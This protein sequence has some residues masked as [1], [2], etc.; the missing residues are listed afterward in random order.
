[1]LSSRLLTPITRPP[2]VSQPSIPIFHAIIDADSYV[3]PLIYSAL[4]KHFLSDSYRF[5]TSID[6]LPHPSDRLLQITPYETLDFT[7]LLAHPTTSL[8]NS[9]IIR[10]A[11]IR[12]H[13][14]H[15]TITSWWSKHPDDTNLKGHVPLTVAFEVDY[16]EFLDEAL[17]ECWELHES[18]AKEEREWWVLKP[19]MSDQGQGVRLFSSENELRTIFEEWEAEGSDSEQ[20]DESETPPAINGWDV[21]GAGTMTSQ[22]RHFIAQK[23][24]HPPLLLKGHGNRKFHIRSYVLA[25]G[26]LK[27]YVY[28]EM[29]ALFAPELYTAPGLKDPNSLG[30]DAGTSIDPRIHLTN[31]CL[32]DGTR[33]GSVLPFWSLSD[34]SPPQPVLPPDWKYSVFSQ[35][36]AATGTL[37]EAA[38]REQ[39]VHFQTLG[40]A[41]EVFGVD[42]MV[43]ADGV[44]WLLEVN[45]FPDFKQSG[46]ELRDLVGG[47]WEGIVGVAVRGFFGAK[48]QDE[49]RFGLRK[50]LDV[51]LGRR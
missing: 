28:R 30:S 12:K 38:A 10:K 11:I 14:L 22:L 31:T 26:A 27:T 41:F 20:E 15:N 34:P 42:W 6:E 8:A 50:V 21:I 43:D 40:N 36:C 13:Y 1:M 48:V 35:I 29:L 4:S 5:I 19:G 44:V 18:F 16:A 45:S 47:L 3:L 46:D 24:V 37:F 23:Y 39:M 33:E 17:A 7:H 9:Y 25:V 32:Q 49:E 51:D 2:T